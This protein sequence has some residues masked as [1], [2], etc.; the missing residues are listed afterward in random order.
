VLDGPIHKIIFPYIRPLPPTP[1][2]PFLIYPAQIVWP[3]YSV[4]YSLPRPFSTVRLKRAHMRDNFL[5]DAKVSQF[6]LLVWRANLAASFCTLSNAFICPS[7]YGFQHAAPY[8]RI[9]RRSDM[10]GKLLILLFPFLSIRIAKC[11]ALV[12]SRTDDWSFLILNLFHLSFTSPL[13]GRNYTLVYV[14]WT[15][16]CIYYSI[17]RITKEMVA[18]RQQTSVSNLIHIGLEYL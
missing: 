13:L 3:L 7:L 17:S 2:F 1:N 9:G 6:E 10:Q 14:L 5:R 8:S 11:S 16:K 15:H 18:E 12:N 4:T